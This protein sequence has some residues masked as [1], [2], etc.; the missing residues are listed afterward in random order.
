MKTKILAD[1]DITRAWKLI[2]AKDQ[3]LG[4]LATR[5]ATLLIGKHKPTFSEHQDGG[6]FVIVINADKIRVT[7]SKADQKTYFTHS[8]YPGA[9]KITPYKQ[10]M[11]RKPTAVVRHAIRG[12]I[13]ATGP[14]GR[15]IYKKLFV[16]AGSEHPHAAQ[17][18]E[19]VK[20]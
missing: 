11:R 6:D 2:D 12:M 4:R 9:A 8:F 7:G 18:P 1:K 15:K 10:L 3:V 16:Y 19:A 17:K 13:K 14:L 5:A 20:L